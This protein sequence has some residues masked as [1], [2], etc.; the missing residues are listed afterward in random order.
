MGDL[1][2][3]KHG[4]KGRFS[5]KSAIHIM[6]HANDPHDDRCWD[7][8]WKSPNQQRVRA[9]L[10]LACHDRILGNLNRFKRHMTT[11]PSC[12]I[13]GEAEESSI[14]ILRNCPAARLVWRKV[15]GNANKPEF[16][17]GDIKEW[18]TGNVEY[19]NASGDEN[20]PTRFS[21]VL[22]WLWRWRNCSQFGRLN[23]IPIDIEAFLRVRF[24]ETVSSL[25]DS[26]EINTNN[27]GSRVLSHINWHA[28][29]QAGMF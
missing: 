24:A 15:G 26:V 27:A 17:T 4:P 16:W 10:W 29:E 18:I 20:W 14:H 25:E 13:C 2:Y 5:I 12:F 23:E 22:W 7:L 21:I 28:P 8:I 1:V 3:W 11:D 6:Q 9:F 19:Q